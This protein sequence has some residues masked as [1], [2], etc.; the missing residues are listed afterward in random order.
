MFRN[1][2]VNSV[3]LSVMAMILVNCAGPNTEHVTDVNPLLWEAGR[4]AVINFD[5]ADTSALY[6]L[7]ILLVFNEAF[8]RQSTDFSVTVMAPDS[9]HLT[10]QI[11]IP[12][13]HE[14]Y[15]LGD[16][17]QLNVTYRDSVRL[18]ME[19]N[20]L[21]SISPE[22]DMKGIRSVGINLTKI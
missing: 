20:Y 11:S 13:S 18:A 21:V 1:Q 19:G 14:A 4:D 5:N 17:Y 15:Q 7:D 8:D 9:T 10:E 6:R 16:S 2:Y 12:F 22:R 3:C